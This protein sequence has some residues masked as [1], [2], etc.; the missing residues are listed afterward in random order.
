[1][2]ITPTFFAVFLITPTKSR[3]LS[4]YSDRAPPFETLASHSGEHR[5]YQPTSNKAR[6]LL[7]LSDKKGTQPHADHQGR[8]SNLNYYIR[9]LQFRRKLLYRGSAKTSYRRYESFCD[10]ATKQRGE[11]VLCDTSWLSPV[12]ILSQGS[13][14]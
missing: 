11:P 5:N 12:M 1:M 2:K 4:E 3:N 14:A 9:F 13:V 6:R 7:S 10:V 8:W